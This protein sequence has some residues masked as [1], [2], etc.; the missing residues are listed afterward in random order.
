M[1]IVVE[2]NQPSMTAAQYDSILTD[3]D[4]KGAGTPDGRTFHVGAPSADGWFVVAVW[5][6]REQFDSFAA[7]LV[8]TLQAA[9]MTAA[10]EVRPVHNII[11][12]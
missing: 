7:V 3:L 2:F 10:P 12:G 11:T 5:E 6:S 1:A 4:Q 8:P 9:G